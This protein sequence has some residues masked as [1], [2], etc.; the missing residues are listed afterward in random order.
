MG[1]EKISARVLFVAYVLF[2]FL[3][4]PPLF[5]N[6]RSPF[7]LSPFGI[8]SGMCF[9]ANALC[10]RRGL[11]SV[12]ATLGDTY[13]LPTAP[14]RQLKVLAR[15][16]THNGEYFVSPNICGFSYQRFGFSPAEHV[17][18]PNLGCWH[19]GKVHV[20]ANRP[21]SLYCSHD[22]IY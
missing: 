8:V 12:A 3:V 22:D 20:T 9:G 6:I 5:V 1:G 21:A 16:T 18:S 7:S 2:G 11:R 17:T 14:S 15:Q 4:N 19:F 10:F 13:T